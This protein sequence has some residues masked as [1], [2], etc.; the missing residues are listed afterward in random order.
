MYVGYNMWLLHIRCIM[1]VLL[2]HLWISGNP[3]TPR[4]ALWTPAIQMSYAL[5]QVMNCMFT[6][7]CLAVCDG[8]EK[9]ACI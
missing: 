2:E 1:V 5:G 4:S 8:K 3:L 9:K 7:K 6:S